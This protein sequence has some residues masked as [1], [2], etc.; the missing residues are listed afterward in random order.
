MLGSSRPRLLSAALLSLAALQGCVFDVDDDDHDRV[1]PIGYYEG[2]LVVDW[3]IERAKDPF[4]C[5]VNRATE[6]AIDLTSVS[7]R[8]LDMFR[9]SCDEFET[10]I[11]LEE[12]DY[13]GY[14]VLL[15]PDGFELTT[16]VDLGAFSIYP[17]SDTVVRINFPGDSFR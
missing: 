5:D 9:Q 11:E 6:I 14:A 4:D 12:G 16:Q 8:P 3:T 7:G 17:D 13:A 2:A 1:D 15:D 10:S